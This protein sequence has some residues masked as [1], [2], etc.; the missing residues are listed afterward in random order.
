MG[1]HLHVDFGFVWGSDYSTKD[2]K[3]RLVT[4]KDGYRSYC[5]VIDRKSRYITV[6]FT[7]TKDPPIKELRHIF[8]QYKSR[9]TETHCTVTTDLGGELAGSKSFTNLLMEK[10][11]S[12]I[13]K[14][15]AAFSSA[16]NGMAEKPN[17]DLARMMRSLLYGTSLGSEYWA[18]ALRH[19]VYLKNRLPHS[20]LAYKTPYEMVNNKKPDLT[21]LRVFGT[22]VHFMHKNRKKKLDRMDNVGTFMTYKGNNSMA[23]VIDNAT[24]RERVTTHL[25]F[26]EAYVSAPASEQPPM[27]TA[28]QQSGFKPDQE[29]VRMRY[30]AEID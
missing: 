9:V 23:Y 20:S 15:T 3:G 24:G 7:K 11:V 17:Q 2:K 6:I 14:T 18:Y 29:E 19:S 21:N 27:G 22:R 30:R 4:S 28:L 10:D 8:Q 12:Y 13:S 25:N 26:D 1:Q 5:L 16:Q